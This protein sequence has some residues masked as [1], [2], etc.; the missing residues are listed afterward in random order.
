M[1]FH[2]V[3]VYLTL[4]AHVVLGMLMPLCVGSPQESLEAS[5][6]TCQ[7]QRRQLGDLQQTLRDLQAAA[8][9]AGAQVDVGHAPGET[10]T[11]TETVPAIVSF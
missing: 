1:C 3:L 4:R 2:G 7:E 10:P 8:E 5:A 9:E 11:T 6:A